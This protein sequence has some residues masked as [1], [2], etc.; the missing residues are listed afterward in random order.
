VPHHPHGVR[1]LKAAGQRDS[2]PN[3]CL[4]SKKSVTRPCKRVALP[5]VTGCVPPWLVKFC[6]YNGWAEYLNGW[7]LA[8]GGLC[9][10]NY[11]AAAPTG[12]SRRFLTGSVPDKLTPERDL[13]IEGTRL[14]TAGD[15]PEIG[16]YFVN[17]SGDR[18]DSG[19]GGGVRQKLGDW[20]LEGQFEIP[21]LPG[22]YSGNQQDPP[23][24]PVSRSSGYE[25]LVVTATN[26]S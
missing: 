26:P 5:A 9:A 7:N 8:E 20:G 3:P 11:T 14:K 25:S 12:A 24:L 18:G 23:E 1:G 17:L 21:R 15:N 13:R 4:Q 22:N 2:A 16:V 19:S 10:G 6:K